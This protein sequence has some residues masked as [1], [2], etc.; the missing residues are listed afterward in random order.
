M[1][2]KLYIRVWER[3]RESELFNCWYYWHNFKHWQTDTVKWSVHLCVCVCVCAH[4][5]R[6]ILAK[7]GS[8]KQNSRVIVA[9][10]GPWATPQERRESVWVFKTVQLKNCDSV[11]EHIP[12]QNPNA[13]FR[14]PNFQTGQTLYPKH[15]EDCFPE[16]VRISLCFLLVWQ[17]HTVIM[18]TVINNSYSLLLICVSLYI[19]LS[20]STICWPVILVC[21]AWSTVSH[22][23]NHPEFVVKCEYR[24]EVEKQT[25]STR[26]SEEC[27][28]YKSSHNS[29]CRTFQEESC[30]SFCP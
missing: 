26:W 16:L 15:N 6:A 13:Q 2:W 8:F 1:L 22:R 27:E 21:R 24:N 3:E 18:S 29:S 23:S 30:C 10:I 20:S 17:V 9:K 11:R 14:L 25:S 28:C 5:S 19:P 12:F 7:I 4:K